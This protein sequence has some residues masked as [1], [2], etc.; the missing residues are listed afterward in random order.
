MHFDLTEFYLQNQYNKYNQK[1]FEEKLEEAVNS[2][3]IS[4]VPIG[5][6]LSGG[7]DS[8]IITGI[9]AQKF[10]NPF[11]HCD[12]ILDDLMRS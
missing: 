10:K 1:E 8:S 7:L 6:F 5:T 11:F 2:H 3:L 9:V 4:D 12:I